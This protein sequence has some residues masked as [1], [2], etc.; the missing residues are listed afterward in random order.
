MTKCQRVFNTILQFHELVTAE[1]PSLSG[2]NLVDMWEHA[3]N[4]G[5]GATYLFTEMKSCTV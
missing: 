2:Q 4:L 3:E 1:R 5:V